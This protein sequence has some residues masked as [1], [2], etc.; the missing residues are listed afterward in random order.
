MITS[1]PTHTSFPY[2]Q[3]KAYRDYFQEYLGKSEE[4]VAYKINKAWQQLFYGDDSTERIY[5]PVGTDMVYI[6]DVGNGDV[7]TEGMSYGMMI[8]VQLNHKEEFDRLWKWTKT[9]MYQSE[10]PFRGYFAWHCTPEGQKLA[11]NPAS[12]GEEWFVMALLFAANRWGNGEGIFN[13]REEAQQILNTMLHK[14]KEDN[15]IATSMFDAESK[16]VVFVPSGRYATFTNP[17]YHLPFYYELWARWA[18]QDN[19]FWHKAAQTSRSFFHKA[20]HPQ[21]GLMP[22]YANFDGSPVSDPE[23]ENF[24]FDAWRTLANVAVDYAWFGVDPWQIEQSNRV[25]DFLTSHGIHTFPN[26]YTLDGIPLSSEHST[27]LVAMAAVAGM[28]ANPQK[29]EPFI[30]ALWNAD[31]PTGK[32]RY[33]DGMLYLLALLHVSGSFR[34]Y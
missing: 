23:H 13:Y 6:L 5:Y 7:R 32:W 19:D 21:T 20:A 34:I 3:T 4:E 18:A 11:S 17:S 14:S 9:Y 12:D 27:G 29:G 1:S 30:E 10:G 26:Q 22:D 31:I 24:R 28:I 25:L 33:Y 2:Y 8:A 15:G 16:Q